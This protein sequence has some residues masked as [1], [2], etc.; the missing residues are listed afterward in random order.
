MA[1]HQ[2]VA[3]IANVSRGDNA[4]LLHD[5]EAARSAAR[6][7]DVLL[8]QKHREMLDAVETQ[9]DL[10]DFFDDRRLN[11]LGRLIEQQDFRLGGESPRDGQLLLLTAGQDAARGDRDSLMR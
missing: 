2:I 10:L 4:A 11:S 1:V 7:F 5:G 9:N 8:N 6:K 3:Q